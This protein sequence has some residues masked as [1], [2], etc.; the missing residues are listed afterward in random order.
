MVEARGRLMGAADFDFLHGRW[1]VHNRK[2][3]DVLPDA[4]PD[5]FEFPSIAEARPILGGLGNTDTYDI[6]DLPG[7]GRFH[8]FTVR[9]YDEKADVWR[10]WWASSIGQGQLDPPLVGRFDDGVGH[11]EGDDAIGDRPIKVRFTWTSPDHD[12]ARWEQCFS[13]DGGETYATNWIMEFTR[14]EG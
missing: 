9:L 1:R 6:E 5:W 7:R 4:E 8:G 10:I 14:L 2:L 13:Y 11:F 3:R 12:H